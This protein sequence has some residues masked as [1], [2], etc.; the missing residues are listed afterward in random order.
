MVL[1]SSSFIPW[2]RR[3]LSAYIDCA[4]LLMTSRTCSLTDKWLVTVTP[5]ILI[6]VVRAISGR[7]GGRSV[8]IWRLLFSK[9]PFQV[10]VSEVRALRV[11]ASI[12]VKRFQTENCEFFKV[13]LSYRPLSR[14]NSVTLRIAEKSR[15]AISDGGKVWH[16]LHSFRQNTI[17]LQ[18][19]GQNC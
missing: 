12:L 2:L 16:H 5:N 19:N 4:H 6:D 11:Y 13:H 17:I 18:T 9:I 10:K 7:V 3:R 14:W 8:W 15:M 1:N